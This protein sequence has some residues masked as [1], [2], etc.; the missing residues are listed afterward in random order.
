[1]TNKI[2]ITDNADPLNIHLS[3]GNLKPSWNN[4]FRFEYSKFIV[5]RQQNWQVDAQI[6]LLYTSD[7]ADE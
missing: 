6:C 2:P 5:K 3:G 1:M 4:R 7:A